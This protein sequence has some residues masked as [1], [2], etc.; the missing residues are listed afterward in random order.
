MDIECR[1]AVELLAIVGLEVVPLVS[2][3]PHQCG[4]LDGGNVWRFEVEE[5]AGGYFR[6]WGTS[7]RRRRRGFRGEPGPPGLRNPADRSAGPPPNFGPGRPGPGCGGPETPGDWLGPAGTPR[8]TGE[9]RRSAR[10]P[11]CSGP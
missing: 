6:R 10:R 11:S 2:F 3:G 5:R 4:F 8:R 7:T 9:R 1:P